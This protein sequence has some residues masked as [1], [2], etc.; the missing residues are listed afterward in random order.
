M[1]IVFVLLFHAEPIYRKKI[2]PEIAHP[3]ANVLE[4]KGSHP[5]TEASYIKKVEL[6]LQFIVLD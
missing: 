6:L 4:L 1:V 3:I 5:R 2:I